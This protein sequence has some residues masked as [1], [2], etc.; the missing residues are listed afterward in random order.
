MYHQKHYTRFNNE[1]LY[2]SYAAYECTQ[3]Q[4]RRRLQFKRRSQAALKVGLVV[5]L[6]AQ[7]PL[8]Y[9]LTHTSSTQMF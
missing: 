8:I 7:L 3:L 4:E 2:S 5:A 9:V 1:P 6:V